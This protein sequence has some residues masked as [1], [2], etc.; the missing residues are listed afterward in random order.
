MF[1]DLIGAIAMG[2]AAAGTVLILNHLGRGWLPRWVAPLAAGVGMLGFTIW[3]EYSWYSRTAG[4]L[5]DT[6]TVTRTGES[7]A[8]WRPWT[9]LVPLV[10]RFAAVDSGGIQ[11]HP[12]VPD[13]R[14]ADLFLFER[15]SASVHVPLAVDCAGGRQAP[16][17]VGARIADDGRIEGATW[18]PL[19]TDDALY[20]AVCEAEPA[21]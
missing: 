15:W 19:A 13:Q 16:L 14:I 17:A 10:N 20:R 21:R 1:F 9:Y 7:R 5:P 18:A 4:A 12:D 2:F 11:T 3:A 8:A 6:M